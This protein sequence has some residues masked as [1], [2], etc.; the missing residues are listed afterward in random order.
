VIKRLADYQAAFLALLAQIE[1][2]GWPL[3]QLLRHCADP[4]GEKKLSIFGPDAQQVNPDTTNSLSGLYR[5]QC[6]LRRGH[7]VECLNRLD[8]DSVFVSISWEDIRNARRD[9]I[10]GEALGATIRSPAA[11]WKTLLG[12]DNSCLLSSRCTMRRAQQRSAESGFS[13]FSGRPARILISSRMSDISAETIRQPGIIHSDSIQTGSWIERAGIG[14]TIFRLVGSA[15]AVWM[16]ATAI[17]I[18]GVFYGSALSAAIFAVCS[19]GAATIWMSAFLSR[20][21]SHFKNLP[22]R[23]PS[24]L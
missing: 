12:S 8:P 1:A 7:A 24:S 10:C 6:R 2:D 9:W 15:L 4:V 18:G 23:L 11:S 14:Q 13:H 5:I 22:F 17:N 16:A 3:N 19:R 20:V 21:G